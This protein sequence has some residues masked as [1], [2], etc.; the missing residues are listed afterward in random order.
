MV[1]NTLI[2]FKVI[3]KFFFRRI[4]RS[5]PLFCPNGFIKEI[6]E[7]NPE[8]EK[9]VEARGGFSVTVD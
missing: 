3:L 8:M 9:I 6:I 5:C 1:S 2:F 4:R 7:E